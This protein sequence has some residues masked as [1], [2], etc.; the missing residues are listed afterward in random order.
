MIYNVLSISVVQQSGPVRIAAIKSFLQN[1]TTGPTLV[2]FFFFFNCLPM[3]VNQPTPW[4]SSNS[5]SSKGLLNWSALQYLFVF[6]SFFSSTQGTWK[7]PGQ[8]WNLSCSCNLHC[9]C[10][11]AESLTYCAT[12]GILTVSFLIFFPFL[13]ASKHMQFQAQGSDPSC[14]QL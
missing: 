4:D 9:S 8:G 14:R 5:P 12:A 2:L 3:W 11:N 13:A 7:F 10:G 1:P 6:H